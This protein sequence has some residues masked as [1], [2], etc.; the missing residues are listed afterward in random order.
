MTKVRRI[1]FW[2]FNKMLVL[3]CGIYL[4]WLMCLWT[5][6]MDGIGMSAIINCVILGKMCGAF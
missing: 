2:I 5:M 1:A 6:L 3:A 4:A